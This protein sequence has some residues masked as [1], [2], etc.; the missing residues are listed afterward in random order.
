MAVHHTDRSRRRAR[1]LASC[2]ALVLSTGLLLSGTTTS[3]AAADD[4]NP[5]GR[6]PVQQVTPEVRLPEGTLPKKRAR[7]ST[8]TPAGT[9]AAAPSRNDLD[10]D[11]ESDI[12]YRTLDGSYYLK[13]SGDT[14]NDTDYGLYTY[15]EEKFKDVIPL[16]DISGDGV[17]DLLSLTQ[18]GKLS[19][20]QGYYGGHGAGDASWSGN[21]WQIYNKVLSTGDVTGDGKADVLARTPDGELYLYAGTGNAAGPLKSRVKVGRGWQIYDQLV[22]VSDA[23][24]DGIGD[25]YARTPSGDLY[26]YAGSGDAAAPLKARVKV[27]NS[28]N[29]YNQLFS[30]DDVTGDGIAEL[31][32]RTTTGTTYFYLSDGAG[33]PTSRVEFGVGWNVVDLLASQGGNTLLGKGTVL[34]LDTKG[35]LFLYGSR[36]NGTLTAREQISDIGGWQGARITYANSLDANDYADL[37]EVYDGYLYNSASGTVLGS[38]WNAFNSLVGPG[39]LNDDGK[40]DLLA[41]TKSGVLYLYRGNGSGTGFAPRI[42]VGSGWG[43]YNALVG[44]GDITGDGRA[45]LL[46][47]HTDGSLYLYTGT[48]NASAPFK[49]RV[50]IGGGWNTYNKL[51]SPGDIS[52]D[53]RADLLAVSADGTLYRYLATYTGTANVFTPRASLGGGWNTYRSLH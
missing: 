25:L 8:E 6:A 17:A 28:W 35:T 2:T 1:R 42:S 37:M 21:G 4:P 12:L 20:H 27:G 47:R 31:W 48:G 38:G 15:S 43:Q 16:G 10:G 22:G 51:V 13:H 7:M 5:A 46:A 40:G 34:G 45:D 14:A 18:Y 29:T 39:D 26:F 41:R 33:R 23:N 36:N 32:G 49:A 9:E 11:G 24:G 52:G 3:A 30:V 50:R 19:L 44:A 53:G